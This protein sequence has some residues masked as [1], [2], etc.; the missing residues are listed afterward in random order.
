[1]MLIKDLAERW[2]VSLAQA[3]AI[4]RDERVPFIALRKVDMRINWRYARFEPEA[5][6]S[7]ERGRRQVTPE[8]VQAPPRFVVGRKLRR[9]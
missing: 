6:E 5:V 9:S 1:M 2:G 7:W 3:K 4:V 8:P